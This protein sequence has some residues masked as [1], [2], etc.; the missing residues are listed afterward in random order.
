ML[1]R[2]WQWHGDCDVCTSWLLPLFTLEGPIEQPPV[3]ACTGAKKWPN[4][5][6]KRGPS[7]GTAG[8]D[9]QPHGDQCV[10]NG[11]YMGNWSFPCTDYY[12]P[13]SSDPRGVSGMV[14]DK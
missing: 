11:G 3:T 6:D 2:V 10:V 12:Y 4:G 7:G 5:T 1:T 13:N 14:S 8:C 9:L